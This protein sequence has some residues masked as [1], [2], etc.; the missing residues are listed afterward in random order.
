[1]AKVVRAFLEGSQAFIWVI[2][3]KKLSGQFLWRN[4]VGKSGKLTVQ[5]LQTNPVQK[6]TCFSRLRLLLQGLILT[7]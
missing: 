2:G 6:R 1:M 3:P 4:K 5:N 7:N